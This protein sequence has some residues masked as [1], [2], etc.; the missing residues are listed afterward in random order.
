MIGLIIGAALMFTTSVQ[1]EVVSMIGKVVDGAFQVKVNGKTLNNQA[2]VIEGTSYLPVREFGESLGMDVKFD[3]EMGVELIAKPTP[4]TPRQVD[5]V[6]TSLKGAIG[7]NVKSSLYQRMDAREPAVLVTLDG[8]DYVTT[9]T[10]TGLYD[11][12]WKNP[13]LTFTS[14]DKQEAKI[15]MQ[16][17]YV[18]G[19]DGFIYQGVS[20]VKLSALGLK[21]EVKD[22]LLLIEKQ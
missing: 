20:Y 22:N 4:V 21:G 18:S 14:K 15:E 16:K 19:T 11:M 17:E 6:T 7:Y 13:I 2:I 3:A 10:F 8:Q 5:P 12:A 9:G 1:A